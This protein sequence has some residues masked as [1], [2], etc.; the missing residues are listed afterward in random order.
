MVNL[1]FLIQKLKI[2]I[3]FSKI[4][5]NTEFILKCFLFYMAFAGIFSFSCFIFEEQQQILVF[6]NFPSQDTRR[7]DLLKEN[8]EMLEQ[9]NRVAKFVNKWFVW[10]LPPQQI[11]Y[12][13]YFE[14][15]D[16]YIVNIEGLILAKDP[17]L[18]IGEHIT[19]VFRYTNFKKAKNGLWI[20]SNGKVK[21]V[22]SQEPATKSLKLSGVLRPDPDRAGGV[23]LV[24][25]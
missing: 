12:R 22:L 8:C 14:S 3:W 1:S 2:K 19:M 5:E 16:Q 15:I 21:V 24:A 25:E 13:Y 11:A 17:S 18:F 9:S 6:S 20:A 10:M 23:I 7:Y 4:F